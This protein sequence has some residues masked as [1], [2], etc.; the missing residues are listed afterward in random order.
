[1][2]NFRKNAILALLG[3]AAIGVAFKAGYAQNEKHSSSGMVEWLTAPLPSNR[4][5][6]PE[7]EEHGRKFG[8]TVPPPELLQPEIDTSLPAYKLRTDVAISGSFTGACS[9]V[10]PALVKGWADA[11]RK[12]YP[13]V[14]IQV[15]P[16]FA[17]SVGAQ[18]LV[19]SKLDFVFVSRELRPDDI[20]DFKAKFG[21]PPLSVPVS[22]GS[23][24]H[25]GF[26]DSV[27]FIVNK[28]NP[29]ETLSF[30]QLDSIFS[31]THY[32]GDRA[33]KTWGQ[34]G[35][36]GE[37]GDK[38]IHLYG[39]KPWNGYEEFIRQRVL[40]TQS[41]RGEWREDITFDKVVFPIAGRVA[42]DRYGIGYTGVAYVDAAVK[43]VAVSP[44]Q[45]GP[46]YSATYEN[47][48][49][50]IYPLT[51]LIYFNTNKAR[52]KPL[53]PALQEFLRFILSREGQQVI[54]D[55]G[56]FIPLRA[57]QASGFRSLLE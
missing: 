13:N 52:D 28:D 22:G 29:I 15:P 18:E 53:N 5:Q 1:M 16:P 8:R 23:Y 38:P 30:A 37:W 42:A 36:T 7:Q 44:G 20:K 46:Y 31:T 27:S 41:Q 56:I 26:L 33:I 39:I 21:Y 25:Y 34:L 3:I 11:F 40:S 50:A 6:S 14:Q 54:L 48:A 9:D 47:V 57:D 10:L 43:M 32:R 17:G 19:Q 45:A 49:R 2:A 24:R 4:P 12:Y 51:R 35:L 55:Q